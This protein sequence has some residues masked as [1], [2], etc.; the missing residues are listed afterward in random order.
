MLL[1]D[2]RVRYGYNLTFWLVLRYRRTD[3]SVLC[4]VYSELFVVN[5]KVFAWKL[6]VSLLLVDLWY[7]VR[8]LGIE[9]L[10]AGH[11]E[12]HLGG[13]PVSD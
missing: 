8:M 13:S 11:F 5:K 3:T 7:F 4:I 9:G 10:G 12:I 2:V 6:L 1:S